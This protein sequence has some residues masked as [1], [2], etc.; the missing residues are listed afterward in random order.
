MFVLN[1]A[2]SKGKGV[3]MVRS[4]S[5]T[6]I[7]ELTT[8]CTLPMDRFFCKTSSRSPNKMQYTPQL[9]HT[10]ADWTGT[11]PSPDAFWER[12]KNPR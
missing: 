6:S 11:C 10:G 9:N 3:F 2:R 5:N 1:P 7:F 4:D 8:I 12:R